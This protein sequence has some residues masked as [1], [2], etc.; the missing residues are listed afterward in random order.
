MKLNL[1]VGYSVE[2]IV[3]EMLILNTHWNKL[4][5]FKYLYKLRSVFMLLYHY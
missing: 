5:Y 4:K 1:L 3:N 2:A